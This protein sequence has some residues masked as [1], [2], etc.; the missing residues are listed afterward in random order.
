[1]LLGL[2]KF[3]KGRGLSNRYRRIAAEKKQTAE[4]P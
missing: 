2:Y 3:S 1:M 4:K